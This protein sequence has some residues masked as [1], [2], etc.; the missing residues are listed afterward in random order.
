MCR[1]PQLASNPRCLSPQVLNIT[2]TKVSRIPLPEHA[3]SMLRTLACDINATA[4]STALLASMTN[5][6]ELYLMGEDTISNDVQ[7][8]EPAAAR[9]LTDE[10]LRALRGLPRLRLVMLGDNVAE[11]LCQCQVPEGL[12]PGYRSAAVRQAS[13][14]AAA[15]LAADWARRLPG[16]EVRSFRTWPRGN[17]L[18]TLHTVL[19]PRRAGAQWSEAVKE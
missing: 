16:R 7:P 5:L 15:G 14:V 13:T 8:L 12:G 3:C 1:A 17:S 4:A 19:A 11:L 2:H 10:L 18:P 9:Q 6:E